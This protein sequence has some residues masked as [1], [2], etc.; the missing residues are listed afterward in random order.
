MLLDFTVENFRSIKNKVT[1]SMTR[2]KRLKELEDSGAIIDKNGL[3]DETLK[4]AI[5][6][7]ANGSGKSNI[8]LALKFMEYFVYNST[9]EQFIEN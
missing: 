4:S 9:D 8:I 7:G 5:I 1:L 6:Y 2:E 3:I